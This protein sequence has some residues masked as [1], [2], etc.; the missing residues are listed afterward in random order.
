M[1]VV[2]VTLTT[3]RYPGLERSSVAS[4]A[5]EAHGISMGQGGLRV[6][7]RVPQ[8]WKKHFLGDVLHSHW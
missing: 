5:Q 2:R 4:D 7:G 3:M 1:Q 6:K 8:T